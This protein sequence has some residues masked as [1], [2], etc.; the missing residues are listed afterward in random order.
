MIFG[1]SLITGDK[2]KPFDLAYLASWMGLVTFLNR[3]AQVFACYF[4]KRPLDVSGD[5]AR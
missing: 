4:F 3:V 5:G 1:S 2:V